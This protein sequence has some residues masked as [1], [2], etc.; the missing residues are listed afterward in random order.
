MK[1]KLYKM[2]FTYRHEVDLPEQFICI[3]RPSQ[4]SKIEEYYSELWLEIVEGFL[5]F[6]D[7]DGF[8]IEKITNCPIIQGWESFEG[9]PILEDIKTGERFYYDQPIEMGYQLIPIGEKGE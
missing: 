5:V 7:E 1:E 4:I 8:D 3:C 9:V 2:Y 6:D